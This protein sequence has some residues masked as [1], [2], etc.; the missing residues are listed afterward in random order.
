MFV[1]EVCISSRHVIVHLLIL[2]YDSNFFWIWIHLRLI[3]IVKHAKYLVNKSYLHSLMIIWSCNSEPFAND[4]LLNMQLIIIIWLWSFLVSYL[5]LTVAF[6]KIVVQR[7][8]LILMITIKIYSF[9][10]DSMIQ[11]VSVA[12]VLVDSHIFFHCLVC[13]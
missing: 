2:W 4:V 6:L 7:G 12:S 10:D 8:L 5:L 9:K 1:V 13:K 11:L 3:N